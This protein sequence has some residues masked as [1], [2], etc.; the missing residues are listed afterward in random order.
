MEINEMISFNNLIPAY[1]PL[2]KNLF[3]DFVEDSIYEAED[4]LTHTFFDNAPTKK[5]PLSYM[6][7]VFT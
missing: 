7:L 6:Y 5:M 2:Q 3:S 4:G 1:E